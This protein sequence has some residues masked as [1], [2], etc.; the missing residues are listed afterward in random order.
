MTRYEQPTPE[1][2]EKYKELGYYP[3]PDDF[4]PVTT[5][6]EGHVHYGRLRC[7]GWNSYKGRQCMGLAMV[8]LG[9]K[10]D[11]SIFDMCKR[12]GGK[13]PRGEAS[14][15]YRTGKYVVG[16]PQRLIGSYHEIVHHGEI[17][18]MRA[19]AELLEVRIMELVT[20]LDDEGSF[21]IFRQLRDRMAEYKKYMALAKGAGANREADYAQRAANALAA[22]DRL[23]TRGLGDAYKW[24]EI[25]AHT[26]QI[27]KL[28]D[29]EQK[30]AKTAEIAVMADRVMVFAAVMG[31]IFRDAIIALAQLD[32][33]DKKKVIETVDH[34][35]GLLLMRANYAEP[36]ES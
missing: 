1:L 24:Q 36:L 34:Q 5:F 10:K 16:L 15:Q 17:M 7:H 4:E 35:V 8:S 14:S 6:P 18:D 19:R 9:T 25:S 26:E 27:R 13:V 11:G 2:I 12:H 33:D 22:I 31:Q 32:E 28:A 29:T 30:Q 3:K 20:H 23:I 21:E